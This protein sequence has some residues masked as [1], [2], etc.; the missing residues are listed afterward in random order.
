[1]DTSRVDGVRVNEDAEIR[2]GLVVDELLVFVV[3]RR[4]RPRRRKPSAQLRRELLG[5]RRLDVGQARFWHVEGRE[6]LGRGLVFCSFFFG[7]PQLL[8]FHPYL[9]LGLLRLGFAYELGL[10]QF[11]GSRGVLRGGDTLSM[12]S[13]RLLLPILVLVPPRVPPATAQP[14]SSGS[15][16]LLSWS[17]PPC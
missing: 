8:G 3:G 5:R 16:Q 4:R 9:S 15:P 10:P 12:L 1:M 13:L 14:C 2:T 11:F 7:A 6:G 17:L